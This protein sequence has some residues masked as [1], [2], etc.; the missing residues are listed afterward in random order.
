MEF[1]AIEELKKNID[2]CEDNI[3]MIREWG[4]IDNHAI[5][6]IEYNK[7][8]IDG[9]KTAIK[10]IEKEFNEK[11]DY[12]MYE[13]GDLVHVWDDGELLGS[14]YVITRNRDG[15]LFD[16]AKTD[17]LDAELKWIER[18]CIM[19]DWEV[20]KIVIL[21]LKR[22]L[23]TVEK[24]DDLEIDEMTFCDETLDGM[25]MNFN[26]WSNVKDFYE[27]FDNGHFGYYGDSSVVYCSTDDMY[28]VSIV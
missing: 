10:Y 19:Y 4:L 26:S 7:G 23:Q 16:V 5:K 11:R 27:W 3:R 20:D 25:V 22:E 21:S 2:G 14:M 9:M 18:D 17:D 13:K 12:K 1:S 6:D 15:K 28:Y 8:A 24:S